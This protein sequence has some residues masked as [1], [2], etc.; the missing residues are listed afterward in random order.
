[1]TKTTKKVMAARFLMAALVIALA[2]PGLGETAPININTATVA[3]LATIN[4]I[5]PAKAKA[6]VDHREENGSFASVDDLRSVSGIGDKLLDRMRPQV[7]V[8]AL[9]DTDKGVEGVN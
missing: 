9:A 2:A 5:G 7:T 8:G 6:I 3:E 1:M 4:G